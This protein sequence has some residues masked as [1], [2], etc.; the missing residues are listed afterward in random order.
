MKFVIVYNSNGDFKSRLRYTLTQIFSPE[1]CKCFLR[2]LTHGKF[3]ELP[4]WSK[5]IKKYRGVE[6]LYIDEFENKYPGLYS[7]PIVLKYERGRL[8]EIISTEELTELNSFEEL[9]ALVKIRFDNEIKQL[10]DRR[11][12]QNR[13]GDK[14]WQN[15]KRKPVADKEKKNEAVAGDKPKKPVRK[16]RKPQ[17]EEAGK[18]VK[19]QNSKATTPRV[20][21]PKPKANSTEQKQGD[22]EKSKP[23]KNYRRPYKKNFKKK[24]NSEKPSEN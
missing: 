13:S 2:R 9:K 8:T 11:R 4:Q 12:K 21:K 1:K 17:T 18:E 3:K 24:N 10:R 23:K 7:Y 14:K 15:K 20:N 5:F 16:K 19:K 22:G 6:T